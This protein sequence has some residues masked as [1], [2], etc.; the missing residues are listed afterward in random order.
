MVKMW[1]VEDMRFDSRGLRGGRLRE[2]MFH[3]S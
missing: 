2:T 3:E 1:L